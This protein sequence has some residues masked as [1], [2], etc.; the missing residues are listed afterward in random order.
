MKN[1]LKSNHSTILTFKWK[2]DKEHYTVNQQDN[3]IF[4]VN[5]FVL[6]LIGPL[7]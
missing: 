6:L 5:N 2:G 7:I 3:H 4:V 1:T